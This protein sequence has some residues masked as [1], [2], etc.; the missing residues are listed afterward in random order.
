MPLLAADLESAWNEE[1]GPP[2]AHG[3]L[4]SNEIIKMK[5]KWGRGSLPAGVKSRRRGAKRRNEY[6]TRLACLLAIEKRAFGATVGSREGCFQKPFRAPG[7][8]PLFGRPQCAQPG[9]EL[10]RLVRPT[11][12]V[13]C[14]PGYEL[15]E[16][17]RY[18]VW[19][20]VQVL[21]VCALRR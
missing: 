10:A 1:V 14:E 5:S 4:R 2:S 15:Q 11:D 7:R 9:S 19:K 12:S 8:S 13:Q 16:V 18:P 3:E 17:Q 6:G 21:A 20:A